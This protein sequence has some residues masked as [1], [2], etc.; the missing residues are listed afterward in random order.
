[1]IKRH[2]VHTTGPLRSNYIV[3]TWA[4]SSYAHYTILH[5]PC[6][7]TTSVPLLAPPSRTSA[8]L[9]PTRLTGSLL[10][11]SYSSG[12]EKCSLGTRLVTAHCTQRNRPPPTLRSELTAPPVLTWSRVFPCRPPEEHP[13]PPFHPSP[14]LSTLL[15]PTP[16]T[17]QHQ[18][19]DC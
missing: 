5:S 11:K 13:P 17:W 19:P 14:P 3:I 6:V 12:H 8:L 18:H 1:M 10:L 7:V 16:P 2:L 4:I 9:N 15:Y